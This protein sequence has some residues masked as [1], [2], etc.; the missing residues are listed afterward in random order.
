MLAFTVRVHRET[1]R[2]FAQNLVGLA[3]LAVL[4]L[5]SLHLL[6]YIARQACS[7]AAIDLALLDP[8]VQ[9][10]WGAAYLGSDR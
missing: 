2:S 8:I 10:G 7:L 9:R 6:G 1:G 3:K 4:P 5:K